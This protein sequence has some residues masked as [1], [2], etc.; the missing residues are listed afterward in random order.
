MSRRSPSTPTTI[1]T[2]TSNPPSGAAGGPERTRRKSR[3]RGDPEGPG[4]RGQGRYEHTRVPRITKCTNA[5]FSQAYVRARDRPP[6]ERFDCDLCGKTFVKVSSLLPSSSLAG[7]VNGGRFIV[8]PGEP[9]GPQEERPLLR[10]VPL[11]GMRLRGPEACRDR[12]TRPRKAPAEKGHKV[13]ALMNL[14]Y[15]QKIALN[16]IIQVSPLS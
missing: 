16:F 8:V 2:R 7:G 15:C 13:I 12:G 1:P 11:S 6:S 3:A 4:D 5:P 10:E 14:N 9:E